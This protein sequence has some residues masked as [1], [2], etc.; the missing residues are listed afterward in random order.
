MEKP[1]SAE[2]DEK[3]IAQQLTMTCQNF[4]VN[5]EKVWFV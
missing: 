2:T 5:M 4:F 1:V 3:V